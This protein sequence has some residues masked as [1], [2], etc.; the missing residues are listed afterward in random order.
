MLNK[1]HAL[2]KHLGFRRYAENIGWMFFGNIFR[3]LVTL[4]VGIWLVRYLGPT[5]FGVLSY[6]QSVA[7]ILIT[8]G[9][10]GFEAVVVK[11]LVN[12]QFPSDEILTTVLFLKLIAMLII[13]IVLSV[14][15]AF[16]HLDFETNLLIFTI[17]VGGFFVSF[18]IIDC[19]FQ[20]KVLSKFT[21][22]SNLIAFSLVSIFKIILIVN[23]ASLPAFAFASLLEVMLIS[24]F[25][26]YFYQKTTTLKL[27]SWRFNPR[28]AKYLITTSWPL[29]MSVSFAVVLDKIDQIM[30]K[31]MLGADAVGH[32]VAAS[33]LSEVWYFVGLAVV[34]SLFPAILNA[35]NQ[36]LGRYHRRMQRLFDLMVVLSVTIALPVSIF[37]EQIITVI[38]GNAY[39]DSA[40][41]LAIHIWTGLFVFLKAASS[42]WLVVNH[43]QVFSL[44]RNIAAVAININLN[45]IL[46]PL[47]GITGSAIS[48][49]VTLFIVM[50]LFTAVM[51]STRPCFKLQTKAIFM[52][53]LFRKEL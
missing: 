15:L 22:F 27:R 7:I 17:S 47:Y 35:H 52:Q 49:L 11:A 33:K 14:F 48:M 39:E 3:M 42:N 31:S 12:N 43:L 16:N 44:Y 21:V 19:Y 34:S 20:S 5:K 4:F 13:V 10:L 50:Y 9:G 46:I 37:S 2:K 25:L 36:D 23:N 41:V 1:F 51:P 30:I 32:Y 28:I 40:A 26:I 38:Y 29:T 24:I 53:F 8:I 45:L 18:N 6:A